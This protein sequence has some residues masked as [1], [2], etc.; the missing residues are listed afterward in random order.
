MSSSKSVGL[1][2]K[3]AKFLS[4][5]V[6]LPYVGPISIWILLFVFAPLGVVLYFS[7]LR[8]GPFGQILNS[9]T[10]EHYRLM[11]KP[12]Y[13]QVF[14]RTFVFSFGTNIICLLIGYPLAYFIVRCGGKWKTFLMFLVIVPSWTCYLI[15]L[16]ALKTLT[17]N[18]GLINEALLNLGLISSPL[19]ILYTPFAVVLGLVFGFLPFMVLP[20]Y[21]SLEGLDPSL[22]E[23]SEDL[24]ATPLKRFFTV[25][26]PLTKGGI[27]AGTILVF[28]PSLGEWLVP[29]L[30]GG[31][32]VM[33]AGNLIEEQYIKLGNIP[34]GS[35][36]AVVLTTIV[37]L[38]IYL[39]VKMGGEE[40]LER[41]M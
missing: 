24:G 23:A 9:F 31:A 37:V 41:M 5:Q 11:L 27:L 4:D 32:K 16:Y 33:M 38:I 7:F 35:S 2:E 30:L 17:G 19:N 28:I 1:R 40:V 14:M 20:I 26:L 29:M 6:Y 21:A 25:T 12:T 8:V 13:I 34:A 39:S 36:I 10:L 22:L 18:G 3:A 15:R